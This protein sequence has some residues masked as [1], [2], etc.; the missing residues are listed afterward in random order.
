[1]AAE[2]FCSRMA[3]FDHKDGRWQPKQYQQQDYKVL[4]NGEDPEQP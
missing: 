3:M 2:R 4:S 1:M